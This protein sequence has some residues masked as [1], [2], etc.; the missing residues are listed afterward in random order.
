MYLT[1]IRLSF[2]LVVP[3][4]ILAT[5]CA[6][7]STEK[8]SVGIIAT[9]EAFKNFSGEF[10]NTEHFL[11]HKPVSIAVLPFHYSGEKRL[12]IDYADEDPAKIIRRGMYNHISS[13]P[14]S[15]LEIFDIDK[16]LKNAGLKE[17]QQVRDLL[18]QN[19]K[20]LKSIL[21]VDAVITGDVTHFD[22]FFLGIYSQIAV[23]CE[24]KLIDLK[25]GKL[26]WRAK[27]VSRAHAGGISISPIGLAMATVASVWNLRESEMLTQTD[28]LFREIVS[29]IA[30]PESVMLA[31][32]PVPGIDLFAALN[33]GKPFTVGQ[34]VSFR[35]V[36][37]PGCSAY[38]DLGDFKYGIPLVPVPAGV[39]LALHA[40][41]LDVIKKN[42]QDTGHSLTPELIEAVR[43]ELNTREIYEGHYM[44]EPME[45]SYGLL[46]KAYLVN[47]AGNRRTA[48]D[49]V[50][51]V[52]I[53]ARPP[54]APTGLTAES[55]DEK[56]RLRWQPN[57]EKDLAG[58][59]IWS[60]PSPLSGYSMAARSEKNET[61]LSALPNFTRVYLQV[62]AT[63]GADNAG[64]FSEH[65]EAVPLPEPGLYELPQP[66]PV[67][68]GNV[69]EK[70]LLVA[71]K[72]PYTVSSDVTVLP[73][74]A[75]YLEPGVEVR[76]APETALSIAGGDMMAYGRHDRP[77]LFRSKTTGSE[78]GT[79]S[80]IVLDRAG[81]STLKYVT[82]EGATTGLSITDSAPLIKAVTVKGC[83]QAG[84]HLK[85]NARPN[86]SCSTFQINEGQG[87]MVIEGEGV[88]PVI[89][90]N[91]FTDNSPFQVQSYTP[92]RIDLSNNYWGRSDPSPDWFLGNVVWQPALSVPT[93]F[94]AQ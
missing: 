50:H 45:E 88:S 41:V 76:F 84:L 6:H 2:L 3:A 91:V 30:I 10:E 40:E 32:P 75:V 37:E 53:D 16:R 77:I 9:S 31:Q 11:K 13:L 18:A 71:E 26:M 78:P 46:A 48:L 19:P 25:N 87:G 67:L 44:V 38:V 72:N 57:T 1:R 80:G 33:T 20:K 61:V 4:L 93:D 65:I 60:S 35:I 51:T 52:D 79:W 68:S 92:L 69:M 66:G 42:Y 89:R 39:K 83:S 29:T 47:A 90:N 24:V 54:E 22:R 85:D 94:C 86:I 64:G 58:Y 23:G 28:E 43:K 7:V 59:E 12:S 21:G 17:V 8:G 63:D 55:L 56:I 27:Q 70:I 74:G 73:G 36:G 15:D 5:G 49:A 62:R 34:K 82:I 81:R 14:F